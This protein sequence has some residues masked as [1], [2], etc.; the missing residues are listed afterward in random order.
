LAD[1]Q[2][3][4]ATGNRGKQREFEELLAGLGLHLIPFNSEVDE[5]GTTYSANARLKAETASKRL[6][7]AALGDDAGLEVEAL[8]G[9]PGIMS[10]RLGPNQ[11]ARTDALLARLKG[12]KRPWYAKFVCVL[13]LATPGR[14]TDLY[15][16]ECPG[17]VIPE[18]RGEAGFGY[19]PIFLIPST[20]KTFGEMTAQ[21]KHRLS[22]R[23]AAVRALI[24]S[25]ALKRLP[26]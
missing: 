23:G 5:T 14:P 3:V 6:R 2:L 24:T 15:R 17:E 4:V 25:G 26:G 18:W 7:M 16:G 8:K 22:H 13:A 9:F 20:G 12:V 10:A 19:D 1:G 21:E 11:K